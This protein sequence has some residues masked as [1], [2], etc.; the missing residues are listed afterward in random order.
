MNTVVQDAIAKYG[1][2]NIFMVSE[3]YHGLYEDDH[4]NF[5]YFN[6]VTGEIFT[7]RWSTAYACPAFQLFECMKIEE[8]FNAGLVNMELL[9]KGEQN[10]LIAKYTNANFGYYS[11]EDLSHFGFKVE[12]KTGRKWKGVGYLIDSYTKS[13]Q[14]GVKQ[15]KSDN[16]YGMSYTTY[17]KIYDPAT[18]RIE[19]AT[20][21]NVNILNYD[22][23][24]QQYK[25][26]MINAVKN[27]TVDDLVVSPR[28]ELKSSKLLSF[29][30][31]MIKN[32]RTIDTNS[33]FDVAA[34]E[35]QK[36]ID[37]R[38]QK[39]NEFKAK[40]MPQLIE[41]VR[42]NTDKQTEEDILKLAEH[43]F[44]KKYNN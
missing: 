29:P 27:T 40:K 8:A 36:K 33:A 35:M 32:K 39:H 41:W 1:V 5:V 21:Q 42:N 14:W 38:N 23:V 12:V 43:I 4:C 44:N 9:F 3:D 10:R 7:D 24:V 16:D 18:N 6:N 28:I 11:I 26:D 37:A 15:W 22:E 25:E 19:V 13:Y 20:S 2:N 17:C 34:D 31:W 30:E